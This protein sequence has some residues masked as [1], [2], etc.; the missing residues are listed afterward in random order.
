MDGDWRVRVTFEDESMARRHAERIEDMKLARDVRDRLANRVVASR[1]GATLFFYAGSR[2]DA[3]VAEQ[4]AQGDLAVDGWPA[5][6][7]LT[8]WHEAA[9]DWEPPDKPLPTSADGR[10]AERERFMRRE[11]QESA[12]QGYAG[13]EVRIALPAWRDAR[14]L[15]DRLQSEGV[16]VAHHW[17]YVLAGASDEDGARRLEERLRYEAPPGSTVSVEGT[18]AMVERNNPFAFISAVAGGA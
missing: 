5:R 6:V 10:A 2:D 13:W 4:I 18:F 15:A 1:D 11:D 17:R 9:E 7:E 3:R 8:R 12:E 14:E 16:P